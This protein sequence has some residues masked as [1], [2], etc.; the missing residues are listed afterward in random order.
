MLFIAVYY[1]VRWSAQALAGVDAAALAQC[2]DAA[3]ALAACLGHADAGVRA[4]AADGA[5]VA[6]PAPGRTRAFRGGLNTN[7][8]GAKTRQG[9]CCR[10]Q[11]TLLRAPPCKVWEPRALPA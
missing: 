7:S 5:A 2:P 6:R 11:K 4:A 9:E 1:P 8:V 3:L 10:P